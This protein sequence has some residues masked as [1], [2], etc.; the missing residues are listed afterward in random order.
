MFADESVIVSD[1]S[2][3]RKVRNRLARC[4]LKSNEECNSPLP[5]FTTI[6]ASTP[7]PSTGNESPMIDQTA[8]EWTFSKG[9][10]ASNSPTKQ[11]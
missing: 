3:I 2:N 9:M 5:P 7:C 6:G 10:Y 11:C 8:F 1:E 4:L